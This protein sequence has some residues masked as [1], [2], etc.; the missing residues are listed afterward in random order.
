MLPARRDGVR[1]RANA[2]SGCADGAAAAGGHAGHDRGAESRGHGHGGGH[3]G[4]SE[5]TRA[6]VVRRGSGNR[7]SSPSRISRRSEKEI[8]DW[9]T[10]STE[11][12]GS[13]F[14]PSV[15]SIEGL[16]GLIAEVPEESINLTH[17]GSISEP[18]FRTRG[19]RREFGSSPRLETAVFIIASGARDGEQSAT[20][21]APRATASATRNTILAA[22]PLSPLAA[23]TRSPE[24][25]VRR[26]AAP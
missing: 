23:S 26:T 6:E 14:A 22:T 7:L 4:G 3:R 24:R 10:R 13:G 11:P 15:E 2:P 1:S 8:S 18:G 16:R 9:W 20:M 12:A 5:V 17:V 19:A 21:P 25:M